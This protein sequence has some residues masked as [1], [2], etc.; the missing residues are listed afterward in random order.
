MGGGSE[1]GGIDIFFNYKAYKFIMS[2]VRLHRDSYLYTCI[3]ERHNLNQILIIYTRGGSQ[4]M[5]QFTEIVRI[6]N[7]G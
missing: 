4:L 7:T 1:S 6:K 5:N 2:I 3:K